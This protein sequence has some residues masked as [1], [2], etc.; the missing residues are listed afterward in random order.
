MLPN[1]MKI[2]MTNLS[3]KYGA[4]L[5]CSL[6]TL[7]PIL[8]NVVSSSVSIADTSLV[9]L[10]KCHRLETNSHI[11]EIIVNIYSATLCWISSK[12]S[13]PLK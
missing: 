12:S 13:A 11:F 5:K 3:A 4:L 7:V 9:A 10:E 2:V 6:S 8:A 1:E